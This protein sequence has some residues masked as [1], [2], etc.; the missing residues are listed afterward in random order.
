[1]TK[2]ELHEHHLNSVAVLGAAGKMGSGISMLLL[3]Q[4]AC[5]VAQ[6]TDKSNS[7]KS[8]L[9]LIDANEEGFVPLKHYLRDQLKKFAERNIN[10]LRKWYVQR[11]DLIDNEQMIE[12][13]I[14]GGM[15]CVRFGMLLEE[16]RGARLV[17]EAIVE[18]VAVKSDVFK[19]L[20][21]ILGPEAFYLTNTSSIPIGILQD[22]SGL[23]GRLIG[24][25]FYNP[26]AVQ[27]LVEIIIPKEI[28]PQLKTIA[29]N[30]AKQ[31]NKI[32]VYSNDIA[33]F[34]GNGHFVREIHFACEKVRELAQTMTLSE[35]IFLVNSVTQEFLLRP[36]GTFQLLDYVGIDVA[37][38][39][40]TIMT[41]YLPGHSFEDPLLDMMVKE[42]VFGGQYGSGMQK[43]GFFQYEKGV[44][45]GIYDFKQ[46]KYIPCVNSAFRQDCDRRLGA[47][48]QGHYS[49]K[50]LTKDDQRETKINEY[51]RHLWQ[52]DGLGAEMAKAFLTESQRIAHELVKDGVAQSVDDVDTVLKNGFFHLYGVDAPFSIISA[53]GN[54]R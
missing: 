52:E 11:A 28:A 1:M 20:N 9:I 14:E 6:R 54:R 51:F 5:E 53:Q 27:R 29:Q 38:R 48:P 26:P 18:D 36:M 49:W 10:D 22:K 42:K 19:K 37:K 15:D 21:A 35:A 24:F 12:E 2:K 8:K 45:T 16:C 3:Q 4:M 17:F 39:I 34:I 33:G 32:T 25:H 50:S 31:L 23:K 41:T 46:K 44:L 40:A 47:L 7:I 13:Y 30:I 43:D